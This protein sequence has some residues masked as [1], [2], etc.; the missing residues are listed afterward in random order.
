M[1][2]QA[3]IS[4]MLYPIFVTH[5]MLHDIGQP[6]QFLTFVRYHLYQRHL[7]LGFHHLYRSWAEMITKFVIILDNYKQHCVSSSAILLHLH[8]SKSMPHALQ[9]VGVAAF[10]YT[11]YIVASTIG[12][13]RFY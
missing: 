6:D 1:C 7:M 4:R 13:C 11:G 8:G 3:Q 10:F 12:M 9:Q 2:A 5:C